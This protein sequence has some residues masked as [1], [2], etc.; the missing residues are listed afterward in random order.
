MH[1]HCC[2]VPHLPSSLPIRSVQLLLDRRDILYLFFSSMVSFTPL[3]Y[4]ILILGELVFLLFQVS[5][6]CHFYCAFKNIDNM[7]VFS[8]RCSY[9]MIQAGTIP[10]NY[11]KIDE[12]EE[13]LLDN[14]DSDRW[15]ILYV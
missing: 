4:S 12:Y 7:L 13:Y 6:L 15:N 8:Y 5:Y 14:L 10:V 11:Q 9:L 3:Y 2:S 1:L